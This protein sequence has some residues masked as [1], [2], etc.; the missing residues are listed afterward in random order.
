MLTANQTV[1]IDIHG[2]YQRR[3]RSVNQE[4]SPLAADEQ[5]EERAPEPTQAKPVPV[6]PGPRVATIGNFTCP[7][8]PTANQSGRE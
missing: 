5:E 2:Q 3:A 8:P 6:L 7:L 1:I 4:F